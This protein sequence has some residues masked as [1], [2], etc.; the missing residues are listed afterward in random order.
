M[1]IGLNLLIRN[2]RLGLILDAIDYEGDEYD[3]ALLSLYSST[4]PSTGAELDEYDVVL[5]IFMLPFPCGIISNGVLALNE[6]MD[7]TG[8]ADGIAVWGRICDSSGN[9]VIDL[10]V[11]TLSGSGDVKIDSTEIYIDNVIHCHSAVITEGNS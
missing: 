1:T 4:R 8:I 2:A 10:S 5:A 6:I 9:F 3:G 7:T 11:S